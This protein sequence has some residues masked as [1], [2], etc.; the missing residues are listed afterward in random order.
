[1]GM[2]RDVRKGHAFVE[3]K[4]FEA[5]CGLRKIIIFLSIQIAQG[6]PKGIKGGTV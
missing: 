3:L 5:G 6:P 2:S 1:M 4:L